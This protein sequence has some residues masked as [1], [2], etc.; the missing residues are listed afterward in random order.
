[1]SLSAAPRSQTDWLDF[2]RDEQRAYGSPAH[3]CGDCQTWHVRACSS[4]TRRPWW[5]R[6]E[7]EL[8]SLSLA[9]VQ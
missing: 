9:R 6:V 4:E 1:V 3:W 5:E 2:A 8:F 7:L